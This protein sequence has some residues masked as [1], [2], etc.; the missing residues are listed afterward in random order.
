MRSI[1]NAELSKFAKRSSNKTSVSGKKVY[2]DF[3]QTPKSLT[4]LQMGAQ[5]FDAFHRVRMQRLRSTKFYKGDQW[6][7]MVVVNGKTMSEEE[8][9]TMQGKPAF[10]QNLIGPPI[11][12]ILGQFRSSPY[13]SVVVARNRENQLASEM[14]T[15]ALESV[16]QMND[17]KERDARMLEEF[18]ISSSAIYN[19]S[20]SFDHERERSFPKYR[21]VSINRFFCDVNTEDIMTEDIKII[22]EICDLSLLDAVATYAKNPRQEALIRKIYANVRDE[23]VAGLAFDDK[24][25]S[26]SDFLIPT[27]QD[28]CRVIKICVKEGDWKLYAHDYAYAEYEVYPMS[29]KAKIDSE[30]ARRMNFANENGVSVPLIEYEEKFVQ[31]W[32]YYHLTPYGHI[33]WHKESPYDHKSHPYVVKFYPLL[34]GAV[35]SMVED[36]I[37]QQKM[38][39]RMFILQDFMISASAKGVLLVPEECISDDFPFEDIADEWVKYNGV[40]KIKAKPGVDLPKQIVSN[41]MNHSITDF[42]NAQIKLIQDIS[43]VHGAAQGKSPSAGTPAALYAQEAQNASMNILDRLETFGSFL[44]KRDFK[45]LKLIKQY[46]TEKHYQALSGKSVSTDAKWFD[47]DII[48][49]IDFENTIVRGADS[50][51]YRMV[52]DD[53][54]WK[55]VE[56]RLIG[57]EMFLENSSYPFA[58]K[59][60]QAISRQ[61]EQL[62]TGQIQEGQIGSELAQQMPEST[63]ENLQSAKNFILGVQPTKTRV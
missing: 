50:P 34:D 19:T 10:K 40:I 2:N 28:V 17:Q 38:V 26:T 63:P 41:T 54:L 22:G 23:N 39:N 57:L 62:Q 16:H 21:A 47:P 52:L 32:H 11:R 6:S 56:N 13:K 20:Y 5:H 15:V 43:G 37:D 59:L 27:K 58:D 25:I 7:D 42:I 46:Y 1:S 8:Y 12:N 61:K 4:L 9:I 60:L 31:T 55:L 18:L 44:Q 24:R 33:L 51:T 45:I 29:E 48:R 3:E 49:N 53:M 30:N 36:L 14:M 35:W